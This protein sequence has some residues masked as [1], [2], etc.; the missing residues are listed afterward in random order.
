MASL[1]R[2]VAGV[3]H[4]VKTPLSIVKTRVQMW[5]KEVLKNEDLKKRIPP[6][7]LKL[8]LDE[9]NRLT[10]LVKRLVVFSRPIQKNLKME[11]IN[12]LLEEVLSFIDLS[13]SK[14]Q[15][16]F[17]KQLCHEPPLI[18]MDRNSFRQVLINVLNNSV[19][20]IQ[21]EEGIISIQ[22]CFDPEK[23]MVSIEITDTGP[24]IPEDIMDKIFE[25]FFTSK[26]SGAGLGLS[27]S[28]EIVAAHK[29]TITF[30]NQKSG[31][32]KCIITLPVT[33]ET[34]RADGH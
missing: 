18:E 33:H 8:V 25:P 11:N 9:I 6:D 7:S 30:K 19:E 10:Q 20:S 4:E 14:K 27:I 15:I 21:D 12:Q 34:I 32:L 17:R 5:E 13:D 23:H 2:M 22:S 24:G 28:H 1:G 29:G 31:G 26:E 16:A 3:A